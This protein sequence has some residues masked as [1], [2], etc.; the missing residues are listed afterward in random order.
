MGIN[1]HNTP[2]V[3]Q[4]KL[5]TYLRHKIRNAFKKKGII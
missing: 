5:L 1:H 4:D 3:Y 2:F